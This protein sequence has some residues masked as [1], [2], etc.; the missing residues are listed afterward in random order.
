MWK[1]GKKKLL[2]MGLSLTQNSNV[3]VLFLVVFPTICHIFSQCVCV[4]PFSREE[5]AKQ[6][7]LCS[8]S[9]WS[10]WQACLDLSLWRTTLTL[11]SWSTT[12][13]LS[14]GWTICPM[15]GQCMSNCPSVGQ[16]MSK[17]PMIWQC[18][19]IVQWLDNA[20]VC[21]TVELLDNAVCNCPT[22]DSAVSNCP[23][24]YKKIPNIN[25]F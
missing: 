2:T 23:I 17:C 18:M 6:C 16:C 22:L 8:R 1:R 3:F 7:R 25:S 11:K 20:S 4:Y 21:P 12:F 24:G 19:K 14:N 15:V 13:W 10:S 9:M 5:Q